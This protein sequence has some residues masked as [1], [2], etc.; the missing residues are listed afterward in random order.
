MATIQGTGGYKGSAVDLSNVQVFIPEVWSSE[1]RMFRD[2]KFAALE[3]TKKIPFEGKKGDLIHIPNISRAA[4][5]DKQPQTPVNLQARTDSEFTFTVTKYKESSF[6]IE[7]IVNTQASYTLRQ[8]YTKEAGYAL[9]RDMDNFA[10]AHRAVINAFP[11]Q[12]I[13][14]YDTTLGDGT[15][16]AHLTG[17]PAPLTYA[18]L[19]LAKQKLDE[20][21]VPQEGRIV[22]VSP[23]QYIDLLSINQFI[24]VDFSQVKPVASG[25]VGTILG[26][27]VIVT[28]QIGINSLTGYVNG[29]G[30]PTQPTPGVLGS[31]YLPDQA[32]TAN[33]VNTGSA[34]D[35]AVSL[36][37]F[38]LPVFSGAGATA[39]DGGQTLGSFGGANRWATAVV[40]HP[41]WLAVGV[42]QNVK[43]E[44]SRET[45]YL[46]DAFVTSC[47]Y[48]AKVFRPDH[49][50]VIH[51]SGI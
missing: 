49:A 44:S 29:Q 11:S 2:Q 7:D 20:A 22:M 51:T 16:N 19:L 18:A 4:V 50:V 30:A 10:L 14:S 26:M 5:Y 8:Y 40:C 1:V 41:D 38:G 32:G 27:E 42:Q 45:M 15:V 24:S 23:A 12:R 13:Y 33:V 31:P 48:G 34:S 47:V 6:M 36:S 39:A 46:A 28:T 25:V 37:Y 3:A 9:A 35:L 17:T 21:D 43:S